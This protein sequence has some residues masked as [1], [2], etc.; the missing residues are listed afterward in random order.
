MPSPIFKLRFLL[1]FVWIA[2]L[3]ASASDKYV[4]K[5][6]PEYKNLPYR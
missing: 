5:K 2:I 6:I 4:L 3:L 1:P